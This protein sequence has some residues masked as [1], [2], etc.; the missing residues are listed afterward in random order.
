MKIKQIFDEI[1]AESSTNKKVEILAKYKDNDLLKKVLYLANSKRVKFYIKQIPAYEKAMLTQDLTDALDALSLLSERTLTGGAAITHLSAVLS[2]CE[3]DDAYIIERIIEKDCKMNLGTSLINKVFPEL[4]EKTPYMG[5][6]AYDIKLVKKIF[7]KGKKAYSQIKMDGRYCNAIIRGGEV[8]LVSRQGEPTILIPQPKF[9][10]ELAKL[11][12]CVLNGELTIPK[13]SRHE[14]N[15][16]ITSLIS[17]GKKILDGDDVTKEIESFEEEH[18]GYY[19]ALN[20]IVFT[21]W[22]TLHIDEYFEQKSDTPYYLRFNR[23]SDMLFEQKPTMVRLVETKFVENVDAALSHFKEMLN[24]GEEGTVLK[25]YEG[26]WK[27]G[28]PI[29][30]VKLKKEINLDLKIVGF[31]YGTGKNKNVISSIDVESSEGLLK[32][33]PTGINEAMMKFI[34]ENQDKLLSTILEVKCSGLSQDNEGNYSVLHPVFKLLR[35][36]KSVANSL[37]ECIQIDK[38]A[39]VVL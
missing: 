7:D 21:V 13:I 3:P 28:K 32:T 34:T 22:D 5:A 29:W 36:D 11:D 17:I 14:S 30:Q 24:R 38:S 15:G 37:E 16:I 25:A 33:S 23:L 9:I 39:M 35:D 20:S 31:N 6:K 19:Q 18:M 1:A 12:D 27:D 4:I 8:E 26:L 10:A 2:L